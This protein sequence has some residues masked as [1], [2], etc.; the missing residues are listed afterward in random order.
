MG[1][2]KLSPDS[3][4]RIIQ[5]GLCS[6]LK[7]GYHGTGLKEIVDAVGVPKGS[8]YNYFRSKEDFAVEIIRYYAAR[9]ERK[10]DDALR[11]APTP[12]DAVGRFFDQEIL[13][14]DAQGCCEGCLIGNLGNELAG[15]SEPCRT[16]LAEALQE[17]EKTIAV[18]LARAQEE[19]SVRRDIPA[20]ELAQC[21]M[22]AWEGSL[23]RMKVEASTEPLHR[24]RSVLFEK[25]LHC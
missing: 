3:K 17:T 5:Q 4:E 7:Q 14:Y 25:L 16:A 13:C 1:R 6:L 8:F 22:S 10:L 21:L 24:F 11:E 23:M 9:I 15:T 12:L 19:G 20:I 2:P 18:S